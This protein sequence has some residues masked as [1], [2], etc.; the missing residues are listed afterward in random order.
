MTRVALGAHGTVPIWGDPT[1][2]ALLGRRFNTGVYL[3]LK[4]LAPVLYQLR[5]RIPGVAALSDAR[6]RLVKILAA[7]LW[8]LD[9]VTLSIGKADPTS[10]L[11]A[12]I[13]AGSNRADAL[14]KLITALGD[15]QQPIAP[16][17]A[18]LGLRSK[19]P[20]NHTGDPFEVID[21]VLKKKQTPP[22]PPPPPDHHQR[23]DPGDHRRPDDPRRDE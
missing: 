6:P 12:Y 20:L 15:P 5:G 4:R 2:R 13:T 18:P 10:R 23:D 17:L 19:S 14:G 11:L 7:M 1:S 16:L 3:D 21:K 9:S 22:E 8:Q